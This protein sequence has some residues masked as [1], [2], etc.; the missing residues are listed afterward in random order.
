MRSIWQDAMA[1]LKVAA[2]FLRIPTKPDA[3][4]D[5]KPDTVPT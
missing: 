5:L 4:S 1:G 3:D 2:S